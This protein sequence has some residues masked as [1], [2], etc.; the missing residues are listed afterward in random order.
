MTANA[1]PTPRS[2]G[3]A[4]AELRRTYPELSASSLRF[5]EREGLIRPIRTPGG[6][7]LFRPSDIARIRRIK[8]WQERRLS[9]AEIRDRLAAAATL[10]PERIGQEFLD[11][12]RRGERSAAAH[13]VLSADEL[14][15]PLETTFN[16][17]LAPALVEVGSQWSAGTLQVGQEHEISGLTGDL[18]AELTFRHGRGEPEGPAFVAACVAGER[19]DLGLR[20][21]TGLLQAAGMRVHFLGV[22]VAAETLRE[23]VAL[24]RPAVVLLSATMPA[25][26]DQIGRAVEALGPGGARPAVVAGGQAC[27]AR[28]AAVDALGAILPSGQTLAAQIAR[29][30][31]LA[32]TPAG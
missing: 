18:I 20:M 19:H 7:R 8:D 10:A 31:A 14:G 24:R 32:G 27:L 9:L 11:H 5:F 13:A 16:D 4:V 23:S 21:V 29:I 30:I 28:P 12:A 2:I 26:L 15:L 25:H 6:H 3:E 22:N 17:V 1:K